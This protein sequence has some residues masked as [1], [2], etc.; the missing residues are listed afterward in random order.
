MQFYGTD[1][2][3]HNDVD[4]EDGPGLIMYISNTNANIKG[5]KGFNKM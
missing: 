1:T 5:K 2:L 3:E 4:C